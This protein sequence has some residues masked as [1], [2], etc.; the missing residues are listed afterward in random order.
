M[1]IFDQETPGCGVSD[2][3][4]PTSNSRTSIL[5]FILLSVDLLGRVAWQM[6]KYKKNQ[7]SIDNNN[8]NNSLL[9][10]DIDILHIK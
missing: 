4:F 3:S 1:I 6:I 7:I 8:N 5:E 9:E 2:F 10:E